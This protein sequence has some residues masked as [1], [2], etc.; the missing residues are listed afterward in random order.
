MTIDVD[1]DRPRT[2]AAT[3]ARQRKAAERAAF[4]LAVEQVGQLPDAYLV[5]LTAALLGEVQR[6]RLPLEVA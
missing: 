1:V 4:R 6:R 3:A 2:A 5:A